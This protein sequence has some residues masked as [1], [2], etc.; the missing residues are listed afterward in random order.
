ML[1]QLLLLMQLIAL[2][3]IQ[4]ELLSQQKFGKYLGIESCFIEFV[5]IKRLVTMGLVKEL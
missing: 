4:R 3:S 5:L 1:L 2:T